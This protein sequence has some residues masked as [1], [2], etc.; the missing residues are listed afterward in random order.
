MIKII[1]KVLGTIIT[2]VFPLFSKKTYEAF[3]DPNN[4]Q[5]GKT[6]LIGR[7]LTFVLSILLVYLLVSGKIDSEAFELL[8]TK[9]VE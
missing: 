4:L 7:V 8:L 3:K 9:I 5:V 2:K 6:Y 1:F